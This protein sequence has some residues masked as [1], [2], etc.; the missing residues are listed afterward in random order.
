LIFIK[1]LIEFWLLKIFKKH[2]ISA[3]FIFNVGFWPA[4][5]GLKPNDLTAIRAHPN[6]AFSR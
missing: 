2:M 1:D 5:K 6:P 4:K 3:V